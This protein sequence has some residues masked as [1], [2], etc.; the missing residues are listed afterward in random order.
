M[1]KEDRGRV[2]EVDGKKGI[3]YDGTP[4]EVAQ[5]VANIL[6]CFEDCGHKKVSVFVEAVPFNAGAPELG[7]VVV[8]MQVKAP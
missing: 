3:W 1:S 4:S 6:R 2:A 5:S 7:P 8:E